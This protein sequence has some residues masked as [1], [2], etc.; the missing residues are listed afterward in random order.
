MTMKKFISLVLSIV[1]ILM[2]SLPAFASTSAA[3]SQEEMISCLID[4]G[5]PAIYLE[6]TSPTA[7]E[8][9][10]L[11]SEA[12]FG[13]AIITTYDEET[14]TFTDY[15][16]PADG[17]MPFGQIPTADLALTWSISI[18]SDTERR[19]TYSYNWKNLPVNRFQDPIAISWD[20]DL[21]RIKDNSF[22]KVDKYD[23]YLI[24]DSERVDFKGIPHSEEHGYAAGYADGVTWY[25]DL[26]GFG[27]SRFHTK[28]YGHAEF[29]LETKTSGS[30]TSTLFGHY[31]HQTLV[32]NLSINISDYGSISVSGISGY[33]ERGNQ[34]TFQY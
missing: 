12:T 10:Y 4:R 27:G 24:I 34:K 18:L 32:G 30:G 33:D 14:G 28:L 6:F 29:V 2:M 9:L 11:D 26:V 1:M 20:G 7:I 22:Y 13:G 8:S 25:A 16:I 23:Y 15:D 31:V 19:I 3:A 17:V 5:Y 21:F